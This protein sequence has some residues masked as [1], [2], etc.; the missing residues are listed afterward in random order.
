MTIGRAIGRNL[1]R[2]CSQM[3]VGLLMLDIVTEWG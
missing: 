1:V 3:I 2:L